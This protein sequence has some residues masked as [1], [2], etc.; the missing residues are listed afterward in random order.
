[1]DATCCVEG[2]Q[3]TEHLEEETNDMAEAHTLISDS[4]RTSYEQLLFE[5]IGFCASC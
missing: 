2:V 4:V 5:G 1:M 3:K